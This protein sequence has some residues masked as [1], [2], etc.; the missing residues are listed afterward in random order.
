MNLKYISIKTKLALIFVT[1]VM[2]T[3]VAIIA[4]I[5]YFVYNNLLHE[6][7]KREVTIATFIAN[8][9]LDSVLTENIYDMRMAFSDLMHHQEDINYIFVLTKDKKVLL[10]TFEDGF[11]VELKNINFV[12]NEKDYSIDIFE[13]QTGKISDI[14]IPLKGG[15]ILRLGITLDSISKNIQD[16]T[17]QF[18]IILFLLISIALLSMIFLF[19]RIIKPIINLTDIIQNTRLDTL[20]SPIKRESNDEVG[21]LIDAFNNMTQRLQSDKEEIQAQS[22]NL[23][24]LNESLQETVKIE[25][26]KNQTK[27]R[28]LFQQSKM[29]SM[30][31]MIGNI[32]H[33]WRQPLSVISM[34][35]NNI[36]MSLEL[37]GKVSNDEMSVC[38]NNVSKQCKHLSKTIDD[39]RSFFTPNKKKN[40][41]RVKSSIDKSISLLNASFKTHDIKVIDNIEDIEIVAF[42]NELTQ[43]II[44][45]INNAKDIL[46]LLSR[47]IKRL[48]FIDIHQKDNMVVIEIKDSG[49]GISKDIID[50]VFEPYFTTKHQ[51]QGTGI[52]LYMTESIITKHLNGKIAVVNTEYEYEGIK[53]SGAK[54]I[55]EIPLNERM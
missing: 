6:V 25:V 50:K 35:T 19:N 17:N 45:I 47:D 8:N 28:L 7:Q 42:E 2:I 54:F 9:Q 52:G 16:I 15:Y 29:A 10:H 41:F 34:S 38:I 4:S 5:K 3:S 51:S 24:Q 43:A 11:P 30:G 44:N 33:Q 18:L 12:S 22:E 27:D 48:I 23:Q 31:E 46:I 55:I 20:M 53:Y 37:E 36:A 14:A 1:L 40:S 49:G 39:F 26:E 32:A 21:I 13:T